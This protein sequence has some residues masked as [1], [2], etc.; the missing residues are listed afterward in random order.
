MR[1]VLL[2]VFAV[3]LLAGQASAAI[4]IYE[5]YGG[6]SPP[7]TGGSA[8]INGALF[9]T[10]DIQPTGTGNIQPFLRIQAAGTEQGYNTDAGPVLDDKNDSWTKSITLNGLKI[11]PVPTGP[12]A[13]QPSIAFLL[14]LNQ[15]GSEYL[16][17]MTEF[18][19]YVGSLANENTAVPVGPDGLL[20]GLGT[21]AYDMDKLADSTVRLDYRLNNGSGSGDMWAYVPLSKL[22]PIA[23]TD[24]LLLYSEFTNVANDGFEE[25]AVR[26][27]AP[28]AVLLVAL[29]WGAAGLKLR[30]FV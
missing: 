2:C 29:A 8:T 18:Q 1:R 30:K 21:P 25:W 6:G 28:A 7:T 14:D 5:L 9:T 15:S 16:I 24:N 23:L 11:V 10:M 12:Q 19:I 20:S 4:D 17:D 22:Q 13:G 27:P 26:V 3:A